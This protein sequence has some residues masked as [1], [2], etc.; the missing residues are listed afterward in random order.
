MK[1]HSLY[2]EEFP[3]GEIGRSHATFYCIVEKGRML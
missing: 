2:E 1:A 3:Q